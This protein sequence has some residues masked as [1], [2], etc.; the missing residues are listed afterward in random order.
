MTVMKVPVKQL[1]WEPD[2]VIIDLMRQEEEE[3]KMTEINHTAY[4]IC[5]VLV[6]CNEHYQYV[7]GKGDAKFSEELYSVLFQWF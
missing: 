4:L 5:Y 6:Q 3:G 7:H 1:T 2:S